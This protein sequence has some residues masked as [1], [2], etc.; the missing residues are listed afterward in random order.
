M[1]SPASSPS[2]WPTRSDEGGSGLCTPD[3]RTTDG[4]A[5]HTEVV[6]VYRMRRGRLTYYREYLFDPE[7]AVM[8]WGRTGD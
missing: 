2:T 4:I 3:Q 6:G 5:F 1:A 8:V 7:V